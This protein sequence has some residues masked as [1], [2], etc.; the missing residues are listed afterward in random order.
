VLSVEVCVGVDDEPPESE[1][2]LTITSTATAHATS[3]S[4]AKM[5]AGR[6]NMP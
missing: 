2:W 5:R 4:G 3:E 1:L 6:R